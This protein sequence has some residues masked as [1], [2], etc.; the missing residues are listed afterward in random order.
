MPTTALKSL[1]CPQHSELLIILQH[2]FFPA[3]QN[4]LRALHFPACLSAESVLSSS[5]NSPPSSRRR[6][7]SSS[8]YLSNSL[9]A[10]L[11][12]V[13]LPSIPHFWNVGLLVTMRFFI[14]I[15]TCRLCSDSEL[16]RSVWQ[17]YD[18]VSAE[19]ANPSPTPVAPVVVAAPPPTTTAG[20]AAGIEDDSQFTPSTSLP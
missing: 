11:M 6:P 8:H 1:S 9:V 4:T 10:R 16:M 3:P 18:A 15:Y 17:H 20:L 5:S 12:P 2:R 13:N 7:K 14:H 19:V